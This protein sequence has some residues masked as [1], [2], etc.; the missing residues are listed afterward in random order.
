MKTAKGYPLNEG[1]F[2]SPEKIQSKID[3]FIENPTLFDMCEWVTEASQDLYL[4][5]GL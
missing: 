4:R 2:E 1:N 3:F 5:Q